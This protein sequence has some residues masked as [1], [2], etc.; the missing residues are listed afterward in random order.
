MMKV[1]MKGSR[2]RCFT[3]IELLV[4]IA[5]IAI[6]ASLL[7]PALTKAQQKA[8]EITCTGNLRQFMTAV[9]MYA[10]DYGGATPLL[11]QYNTPEKSH[12]WHTLPPYLGVGSGRDYDSKD[13]YYWRGKLDVVHCPSA[14]EDYGEWNYLYTMQWGYSGLRLDNDYGR[15]KSVSMDNIVH[16]SGLVMFAEANEYFYREDCTLNGGGGHADLK[17]TM[18]GNGMNAG[19]VDG[20]VEFLPTSL[21][22]KEW[23]KGNIYGPSQSDATMFYDAPPIY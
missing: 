15:E 5:I 23:Q 1:W 8:Q 7:L 3:L 21:L 12:F 13:L 22:M 10:D 9:N 16:P 11:G 19:F 6:L 4:V 17:E 14:R 18:H 20:H 2:N